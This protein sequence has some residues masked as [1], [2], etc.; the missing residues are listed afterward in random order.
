[1]QEWQAAFLARSR[2][3]R[4]GH[5][6]WRGAYTGGIP[7]VFVGKVRRS[8]GRLAFELAHDRPPVGNVKAGCG[9]RDC[10]EPGHMA[11]RPMREARRAEEGAASAHLVDE[12]AVELAL[13]G[14]LPAP[15]LNPAEKRAA[16][17]AAPST[18]P[19]SKL[20]R[21]LGVRPH[22]VAK[23]RAEVATP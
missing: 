19:D 1:M 7:V 20:A 22:T 6:L 21:L 13:K 4:D 23:L 14:A 3:T 8:V 12:T 17:A 9:R 2:R 15:R 18:M 11:D 10:F 16:V 5:R